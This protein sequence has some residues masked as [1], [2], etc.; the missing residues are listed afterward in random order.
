MIL[1]AIETYA[2]N[3]S[4]LRENDCVWQTGCKYRKRFTLNLATGF[5]L[6]NA[7]FEKLKLSKRTRG[8]RDD[9]KRF[10]HDKRGNGF[11]IEFFVAFIFFS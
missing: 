5:S 8:E 4:S 3:G 6:I 1:S 10:L 2:N 9:I 7:H 11:P